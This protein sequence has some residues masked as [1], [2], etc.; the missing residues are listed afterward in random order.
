MTGLGLL[1][2]YAVTF[3]CAVALLGG[4]TLQAADV[5]CGGGFVIDWRHVRNGEILLR[6]GDAF[7]LAYC[8]VTEVGVV[9]ARKALLAGD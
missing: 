2:V 4:R 5:T 9:E 6:G 1:G 7:D 8:F 3:D